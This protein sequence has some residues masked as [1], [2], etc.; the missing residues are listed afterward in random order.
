LKIAYTRD[1]KDGSEV[2]YSSN[3]DGVYPVIELDGV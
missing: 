2:T 3:E 1:G